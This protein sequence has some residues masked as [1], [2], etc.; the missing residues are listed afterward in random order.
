MLE[1]KRGASEPERTAPAIS[2]A[3]DIRCE[4]VSGE[5]VSF[6]EGRLKTFLETL[7]LQEKQEKSSKDM[8]RII[9][10]DWFNFITNH[11]TNH[12]QE[13]KEWYKSN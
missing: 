3:C 9:A 4:L 11:T 1:N 13:K 10:W 5:D 12:L 6:L 8:I 7:G 2:S